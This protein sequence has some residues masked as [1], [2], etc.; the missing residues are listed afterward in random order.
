MVGSQNLAMG[1]NETY[2]GSMV[3]DHVHESEEEVML[4]LA[5]RGMFI[6][7]D[8]QIPLEPGMAV[9]NPPGGKHRIVNTGDEVLRFVWIYAPQLKN[10]RIGG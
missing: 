1:V 5:G 3:P 7:D 4:F 10:H 8:E 9:Y 6:T 2:H